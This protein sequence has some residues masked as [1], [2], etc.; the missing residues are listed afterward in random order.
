MDANNSRL[1]V[2]FVNAANVD[3]KYYS[4]NQTHLRGLTDPNMEVLKHFTA[5][6]PPER[7]EELNNK[8]YFRMKTQ[9]KKALR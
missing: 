8:K 1:S 7:G 3:A 9:R 2:M 6:V 4:K 5:M